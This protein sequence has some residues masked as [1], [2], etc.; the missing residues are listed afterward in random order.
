MLFNITS[1]K[2]TYLYDALVAIELEAN[3]KPPLHAVDEVAVFYEYLATEKCQ[4]H[5]Y[6]LKTIEER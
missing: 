1:K 5:K 6:G 2:K 3:L 4:D